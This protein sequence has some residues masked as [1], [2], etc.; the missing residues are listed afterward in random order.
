MRLILSPG[1][2][3]DRFDP[4]V[5]LAGL[6]GANPFEHV[7]HRPGDVSERRACIP[8]ALVVRMMEFCPNDTWRLLLALSRSRACGCPA[9]PLAY[10]GRTLTGRGAG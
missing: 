2:V 6:V 3:Q 5:D 7:R 10:A 8:V 1:L 4:A 9:K